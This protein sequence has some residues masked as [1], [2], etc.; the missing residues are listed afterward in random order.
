M[1]SKA[2]QE[3]LP[4]QTVWNPP[5]PDASEEEWITYFTNRDLLPETFAEND[6]EKLDKDKS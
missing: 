3:V 1:T 4:L 5:L 2:K 6:A